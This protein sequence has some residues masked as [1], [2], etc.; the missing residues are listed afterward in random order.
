MW[1]GGAG[2]GGG[3][4]EGTRG[5][6]KRGGVRGKHV[7]I[8]LPRLVIVSACKRGGEKKKN[9]EKEGASRMT[10]G[11]FSRLCFTIRWVSEI[12]ADAMGLGNFLKNDNI[13]RYLYSSVQVFRQPTL[14]RHPKQDAAT[15]RLELECPSPTA[16]PRRKVM[17]GW[18]AGHSVPIFERRLDASTRIR[19]AR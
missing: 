17:N 2:G 16:T 11:R 18:M 8:V 12:R 1:G 19:L 5:E 13:I 7:Q 14:V 9:K 4:W 10:H 15:L 3:R 6:G